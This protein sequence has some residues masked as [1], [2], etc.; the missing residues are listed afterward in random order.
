MEAAVLTKAVPEGRAPVVARDVATG[1]SRERD[2][3]RNH[4]K[5]VETPEGEGRESD[6]GDL[7]PGWK[8]P[9]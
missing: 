9:F 1:G 4:E 5:K 6:P 2:R 8:L 7:G 3:S